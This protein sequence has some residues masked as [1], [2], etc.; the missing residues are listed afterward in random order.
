[1]SPE[2]SR[3]GRV[4]P[5]AWLPAGAR[6]Q[7][8]IVHWTAGGHTA[9]A[10]E[11]LHYHFLI[12]ADGSVVRG[13]RGPGLYLPHVRGLNSGSVGISMCGMRGTRERPFAAGT[14]PIIPVQWERCAQA[15]A[16]VLKAYGLPMT[17]R[18]LLTHSEVT[19]VY[20]IVQRGR[21]DVDVLP[22]DLE[23]KA[24]EVH[25]QLRRKAQ[26]YLNALG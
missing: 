13:V 9:S 2:G 10:F 7:R 25:S 15:A 14:A 8:V 22:F 6:V 21:W 16:E 24:A 3:A 19:T 11:R 23:L 26:W 17:Q 20:G 5:E 1:M 18:T 12:Q 4:I